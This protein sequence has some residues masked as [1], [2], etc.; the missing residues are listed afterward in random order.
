VTRRTLYVAHGATAGGD[1][2]S[3]DGRS[4]A[5]TLGRSP[6]IRKNTLDILHTELVLGREESLLSYSLQ[7]T[8]PA[9]GWPVGARV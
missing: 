4:D 6:I 1:D 7:H 5:W 9:L 8:L 2:R 3:D